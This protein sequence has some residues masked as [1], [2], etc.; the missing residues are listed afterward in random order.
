MYTACG[1]L[2][3]NNYALQVDVVCPQ[4]LVGRYVRIRATR[5]DS[6]NAA[7]R[8]YLCEVFVIGYQYEGTSWKSASDKVLN[9]FFV[10]MSPHYQN[11]E[12]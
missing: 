6:S 2:G 11:V 3:D 1:D 5:H 10:P 7:P 9:V 8:L 12:Y 4:T